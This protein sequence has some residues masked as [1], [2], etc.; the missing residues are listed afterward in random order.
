M[1]LQLERPQRED[2]ECLSK[3]LATIGGVL[4]AH[5]VDN[6]GRMDKGTTQAAR[7]VMDAYFVRIKSMSENQRL[8]SRLRFMLQVIEESCSSDIC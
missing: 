6:N 4:D 2:I 1:L 3:L 5:R 7:N 8:E